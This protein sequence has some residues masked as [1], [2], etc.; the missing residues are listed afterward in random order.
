MAD[1]VKPKLAAAV[2]SEI[3]FVHTK[4]AK[5]KLSTVVAPAKPA[6]TL[7]LSLAWRARS[8]NQTNAI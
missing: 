4:T 2:A 5:V 7:K 8:R 1:D 6:A 3:L